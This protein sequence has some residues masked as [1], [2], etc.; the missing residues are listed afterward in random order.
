MNAK[1]VLNKIV[2]FLSAEEVELTYAKLADGTIVESP[3]FDV[4]EDLMVRIFGG[5]FWL[6]IVIHKHIELAE[7]VKY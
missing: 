4:G 6:R 3:T 7:Q 1:K 5:G 2:E